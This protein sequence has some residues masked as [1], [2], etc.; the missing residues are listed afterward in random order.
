[1]AIKRIKLKN[2]KS[3]KEID[4]E[5]GDFNVLIGANA[6]GK[7]KFIDIFRFLK[8]TAKEGL[9]NAVSLQGGTE[10][11]TNMN[12][13]PSE[14]FSLE[15]NSDYDFGLFNLVLN[16]GYFDV[17]NTCYSIEM[18]FIKSK[19]AYG[20][21]NEILEEKFRIIEESCNKNDKIDSFTYKNEKDKEIKYEW[22]KH[23]KLKEFAELLFSS[24]KNLHRGVGLSYNIK[25]NLLIELSPYFFHPFSSIFNR[26]FIYDFDPKTGQKLQNRK[27]PLYLEPDGSNVTTVLKNILK[28]KEKNRMFFNLLK[29]ALPFIED[30]KVQESGDFLLLSLKENYNK[31]DYI[32]SD[33]ISEGTIN[34]IN[35]IAALYFT[36][37][38]Y[39]EKPLT[40]IE[41]PERNMHPSLISGVV[42]MMKEASKI[43]QILITTHNPEIVKYAGVENLLLV[44]RDENG[45]SQIIRPPE[46]EEVKVFMENEMGVDELYVQNLLEF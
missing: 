36:E 28:D 45:F 35:L 14:N 3:F 42:E 46:K 30:L 21:I 9:A 22:P 24:I 41:E 20:V 12:I 2:F 33:L 43:K 5:L 40:I 18:K 27:Q 13:P 6:A 32:H 37:P 44:S 1:M 29:Y 23:P 38:E 34:V 17:I 10:Y 7:S 19:K 4:V 16:A 26:I 25:E 31:K 8:D 39:S 15:I 11:F